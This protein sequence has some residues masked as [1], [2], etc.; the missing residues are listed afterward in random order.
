VI[1]S[2]VRSPCSLVFR[3]GLG[4]ALELHGRLVVM[5]KLASLAAVE[6]AGVAKRFFFGD[7]DTLKALRQDIGDFFSPTAPRQ[8]PPSSTKGE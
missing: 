7:T 2:D 6:D 8:V 5:N 3:P 1:V 4:F